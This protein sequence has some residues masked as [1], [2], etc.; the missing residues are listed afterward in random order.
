MNY[1]RKLFDYISH[2][3]FRHSDAGKRAKE[4]FEALDDDG[5]GSLTEEEFV[6]GCMTDD[7]FVNLLRDFNGD[8]IWG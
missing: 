1:E 3:N 5:N 6:E 2:Y 7:A 4:L 8:F